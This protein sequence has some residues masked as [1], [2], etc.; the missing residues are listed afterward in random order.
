MPDYLRIPPHSEDAEVSVLGAMMIDKQAIAE[1]IQHLNHTAFYKEANQQIF[2]AIIEIYNAGEPVDQLIVINQLKKMKMLEMV[3]GAYYVTGLV[4]ATPSAANVGRYVN[5]VKHTYDLRRLIMLSQEIQDIAYESTSDVDEI[6]ESA[7]SELYKIVNS[8]TKGDFVRLG[9]YLGEF[10]TKIDEIHANGKPLGIPTGFIDYD[11][12]L[13]GFYPGTHYI[14]ARPSMGKTSLE[15]AIA[16]N[17]ALKDIPVGIASLEVDKF[18]LTV[19]LTARSAKLDSSKF[20]TGEFHANDWTKISDAVSKLNGLPIYIDDSEDVKIS[21]IIG[22]CE[23]L[24]A[25]T[26]CKII[27]IDHLQLTDGGR[28]DNRNQQIGDITRQIHNFSKRFRIPVVVL[29]QLSRA[30]EGRMPTLADLRESGEIEANADTV[31]Y[32]FRPEQVGIKAVEGQ[33]TDG[34]AQ[35]SVAKNRHGKTGTFDLSFIKHLSTF[36]NYFKPHPGM[37]DDIPF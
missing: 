7:Q 14:G 21:S 12:I 18:W 30:A 1:A 24:I 6:V 35:L 17:M 27:F 19:Q 4:E 23:K 2:R 3:G 20:G 25:K 9:D 28:G 16:Y 22:K 15:V 31:T 10:M 36:E 5:M 26:D 29:S 34:L 37:A 32:I 11:K 8:R 33:S 13:G